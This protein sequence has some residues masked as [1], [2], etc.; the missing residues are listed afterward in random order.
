[1][2]SK[3]LTLFKIHENTK[4]YQNPTICLKDIEQNAI[5]NI[6]QGP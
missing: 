5:L 1:M 6:N 2:Y 4:F 3:G